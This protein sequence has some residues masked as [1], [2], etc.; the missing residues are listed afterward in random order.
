MSPIARTRAP[1]RPHIQRARRAGICAPS[2]HARPAGLFAAGR[3]A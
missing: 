2:G 1:R 3:L